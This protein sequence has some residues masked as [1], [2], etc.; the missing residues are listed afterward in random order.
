MLLKILVLL[1]YNSAGG[2][3]T[4]RIFDNPLGY[5]LIRTPTQGVL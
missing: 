2:G 1:W 4:D 3:H 5:I